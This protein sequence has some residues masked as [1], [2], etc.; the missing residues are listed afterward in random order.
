MINRQQTIDVS[1]CFRLLSRLLPDDISPPP[2]DLWSHRLVAF[3]FECAH[4]AS[5]RRR[6]LAENGLRYK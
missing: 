5:A 3:R 1:F 4:K 2:L 6:G